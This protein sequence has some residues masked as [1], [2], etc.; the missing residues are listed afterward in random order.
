MD[1]NGKPEKDLPHDFRFTVEAEGVPSA[2]R[3]SVQKRSFTKEQI[4]N[5]A[6]VDLVHEVSAE[7]RIRMTP[8]VAFLLGRSSSTAL[9]LNVFVGVRRKK[10]PQRPDLPHNVSALPTTFQ[11]ALSTELTRHRGVNLITI[12][13][14][15]I[16]NTYLR[17]SLEDE[18]EDEELK[19]SFV[20]HA[21]EIIRRD[22][23]NGIRK[24]YRRAAELDFPELGPQH[25][26]NRRTTRITARLDLSVLKCLDEIDGAEKPNKSKTFARIAQEQLERGRPNSA[27][28]LVLAGHSKLVQLRLEPQLVNFIDTTAERMKIT[29]TDWIVRSIV[30]AHARLGP[31]FD[32]TQEVELKEPK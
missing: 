18:G 17:D 8:P 3:F 30:E 26:K 1:Q 14:S 32:D 19:C 6:T 21:E 25:E 27:E 7:L 23:S 13:F 31:Q 15:D 29:R 28:Q 2:K 9:G 16:I 11:Q 20:I 12:D 24:P 10:K 4:A 22:R 5:G